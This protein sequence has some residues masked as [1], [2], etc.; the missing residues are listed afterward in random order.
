VIDKFLTNYFIFLINR[1]TDILSQ[2]TVNIIKMM[3]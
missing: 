1:F 3:S 2:K